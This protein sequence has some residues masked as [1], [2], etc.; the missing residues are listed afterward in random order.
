MSQVLPLVFGVFKHKDM[1]LLLCQPFPDVFKCAISQESWLLS[2][3]LIADRDS[4]LSD[5]GLIVRHGAVVS[6]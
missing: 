3:Q 4:E 5:E 6:W 2:F 1:A